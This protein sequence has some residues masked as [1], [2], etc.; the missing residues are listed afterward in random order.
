MTLISCVQVTWL[1]VGSSI[2]TLCCGIPDGGR[3]FVP[4]KSFEGFAA[5]F[6][7]VPL[8]DLTDMVAGFFKISTCNY[9]NGIL[10]KLA[11]N[12][13]TREERSLSM[14]TT[15]ICTLQQSW[16]RNNITGSHGR[17]WK[18]S[19]RSCLS[20]LSPHATR[21]PEQACPKDFWPHGLQQRDSAENT[22]KTHLPRSTNGNDKV[23]TT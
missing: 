16:H 7:G 15:P 8:L 18:Q 10:R 3:Q 21:S 1:S 14:P 2:S 9:D 13:G 5:R 17:C 12:P 11:G 23:Q 19:T 20:M 6:F 4:I 22:S